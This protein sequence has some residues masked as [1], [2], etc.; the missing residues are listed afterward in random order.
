MGACI[1]HKH[2]DEDVYSRLYCYI[3][4]HFLKKGDHQQLIAS[5]LQVKAVIQCM[6][7]SGLLCEEAP[8]KV[9]AELA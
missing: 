3:L 9:V 1:L 6:S 8:Q 2:Y 5:G 4:G 7:L